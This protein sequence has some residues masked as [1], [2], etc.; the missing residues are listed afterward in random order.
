M[1]FMSSDLGHII[2]LTAEVCTGASKNP[3]RLIMGKKGSPVFFFF[4]PTFIILAGNED[5]HKI[6]D[7]YEFPTDNTI[8][9]E[10]NC[11]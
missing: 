2:P 10:L 8:D 9:Y 3:H 5:M 6:L 7:G 11:R 4:Y 1:Y